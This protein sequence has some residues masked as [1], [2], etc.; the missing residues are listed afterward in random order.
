MNFDEKWNQVLKGIGGEEEIRAMAKAQGFTSW[1]T[2]QIHP[3]IGFDEF[4]MEEPE[5]VGI[6]VL[7]PASIMCMSLDLEDFDR[8]EGLG[9]DYLE[10]F[11]SISEMLLDQRKALI[12]LDLDI[13]EAEEAGWI[14]ILTQV[15]TKQRKTNVERFAVRRETPQDEDLL[16][17]FVEQIH[18]M[19]REM[20]ITI[21]PTMSEEN[22]GFSEEF[23]AEWAWYSRYL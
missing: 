20:Q 13:L 2:G 7:A 5:I 10:G 3:I 21:S 1:K 19:L 15:R 4:W 17:N 23:Q 14:E 9:Q 22:L 6:S 16:T 8:A 12:A 18:D 11:E